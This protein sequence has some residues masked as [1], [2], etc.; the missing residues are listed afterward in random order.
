MLSRREFLSTFGARPFHVAEAAKVGVGHDRLVRACVSGVLVRVGAGWY[1][2]ADSATTWE[3][4]LFVLHRENPGVVACGRTA[5]AIWGL[6]VPPSGRPRGATSL[7][8]DIEPMEIGFREGFGGLRGRRPDVM[9]RRWKIPEHHVTEGPRG[10]PVTDPLR[11]A[12]DLA[13]RAALPF[14]L[15]PLDAAFRLELTQADPWSAT[16]PMSPHDASRTVDNRL[17]ER[18]ADLVG[19]HGIAGVVR[20]L[21]HVNP[22]AESLLESLVRGRII[23]SGLPTPRLQ[24]PVTGMSG[25]NYRADMA[26]DLPGEPKGSGRLLIEADGLSKYDGPEVLAEEKRRQHDLERRDYVFVRA[27]Y[28]EA[29]VDPDAFVS[30]IRRYV[31]P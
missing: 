28:V 23:E 25:R 18:C 12:I 15:G 7:G 4:R 27:L 17:R 26:L 13:R 21:A 22:L 16:E 30:V 8:V 20:A 2:V 19:G 5:A 11:T 24:V 29:V 9:A 3:A 10:E 1:V 31:Q 6:P 14:A